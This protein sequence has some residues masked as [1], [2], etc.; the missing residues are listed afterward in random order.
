MGRDQPVIRL[1]EVTVG[2]G[3]AALLSAISIGATSG[4]RIA[5]LG[6]SGAGKTTLIRTIAGLQ[7]PISGR[8]EVLGTSPRQLYGSGEIQYLHQRP[9]LWEH[10]TV[11]KNVALAGR[12]LRTATA[13]SVRSVIAELGLADAEH[14]Y[15]FELSE[16]MKARVAL[17]RVFVSQPALVLGDEP[18]ASLD[19]SRREQLNLR[20]SALAA[21]VGSAVVT[22]T[23]DVVEALRFSNVIWVLKSDRTGICEFHVPPGGELLDQNSM[24]REYLLLRDQILT[25]MSGAAD[26]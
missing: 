11:G 20:L 24:P 26:V 5:V 21:A 9:T 14:R 4:D 12:L 17:A 22:V 15:P 19:H 8:V 16:G 2:Y 3:S 7:S 18:F 13:E 10:L 25:L 6:L 23:H 1:H